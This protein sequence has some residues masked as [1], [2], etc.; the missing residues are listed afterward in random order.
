MVGLLNL[1]VLIFRKLTADDNSNDHFRLQTLWCD[2]ELNLSRIIRSQTQLQMLG[3]FQYYY[4]EFEFLETLKHLQNAQLHVLV[5]FVLG[6]NNAYTIHRISIFP[7]FYDCHPAIH[8]VLVESFDKD[9]GSYNAGAIDA[10]LI[11]SCDLPS[12]QVLIKNTCMRFPDVTPLNFYFRLDSYYRDS[13]IVSFLL[14]MIVTRELMMI[15]SHH[16]K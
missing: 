3:I 7:A 13:E 8:E 11:D 15:S 16:R 14:T 1:E 12:I 6:C 2:E 4:N 9:E 5:V 10:Y